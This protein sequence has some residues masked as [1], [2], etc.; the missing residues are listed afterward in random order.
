MYLL[1]QFD[2]T[3]SEI[4]DTL[5]TMSNTNTE[6]PLSANDKEKDQLGDQSAQMVTLTEPSLQAIIEGVTRRIQGAS[7]VAATNSNQQSLGADPP[8]S[9]VAG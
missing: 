4:L 3:L 7:P 9:S 6:Q 1:T 8:S 2:S 5:D